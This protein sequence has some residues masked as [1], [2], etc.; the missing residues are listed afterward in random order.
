MSKFINKLNYLTSF[1]SR[2]SF[3]RASFSPSTFR[4]LTFGLLLIFSLLTFNCGLDI[5]DSTP[6][7]A[8]VWVQK[9]LPEEWP[10]RGIDAHESGGIFLEWEPNPIDENVTTYQLYRA[11]YFELEDSLGDF[12][13]LA[14][15]M[16]ESSSPSEYIDRSTTVRTRYHYILIAE[17]ATKNQSMPSDTLYYMTLEVIRFADMIPNDLSVLLATN[18]KLQWSYNPF[19]DM[20]KY[21]ITILSADNE[22]ILRY[23]LTPSIYIGGAEYFTVPDTIV[24][25]PG[26]IYKWRVD[27]GGRYV[28]GL[29]TVGSESKW[30]IFLYSGP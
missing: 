28:D 27:M 4:P 13:I 7:S 21:T 17:D 14:T 2:H 8:P 18:R 24:L 10:E 6:P 5:E 26:N 15:F 30:A 9:S 1:A 29:E 3:P 20:E 22:L 11:E 12:E 25:I 16:L 19:V 23:E